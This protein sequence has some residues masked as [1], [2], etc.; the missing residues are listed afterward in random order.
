MKDKGFHIVGVP[1]HYT[2]PLTS[3]F[4]K[5][6]IITHC[7]FL[8]HTPAR[9]YRHS[10]GKTIKMC[11]LLLTHKYVGVQPVLIGACSRIGGSIE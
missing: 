2:I 1:L 9:S 6:T 4:Q 11:V 3:G 10:S 8:H 5:H 7:G